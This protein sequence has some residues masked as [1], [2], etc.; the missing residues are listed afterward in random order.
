VSLKLYSI[1]LDLTEAGDYRSLKERLRTLSAR[2]PLPN[3]WALR[4]T[5]TAAELK[6]IFRGF[7]GPNDRIVVTEVGAERASRKALTGFGVV[8]YFRFSVPL[9]PT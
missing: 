5:H 3:Q 9:T 6:E 7:I 8:G 4:S 1:T 2:Q